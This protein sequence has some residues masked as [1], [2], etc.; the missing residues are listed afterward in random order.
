MKNKLLEQLRIQLTKDFGKRC[1]EFC[2]G[3]IVCQVWRAYEELESAYF[4]TD[5]AEIKKTLNRPHK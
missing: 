5:D 3:C 4:F 2:A 1:K